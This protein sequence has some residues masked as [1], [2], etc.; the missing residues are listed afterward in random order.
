MHTLWLVTAALC[1]RTLVLGPSLAKALVF[2]QHQGTDT[3][4]LLYRYPTS[5]AAM[6]F[7]RDS[8]FLAVASSYTY[9]KVRRSRGAQQKS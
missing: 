3:A 8:R 5:V 1:G 9:E 4:G 2:M 7:S 6:S